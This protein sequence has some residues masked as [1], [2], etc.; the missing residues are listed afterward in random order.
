MQIVK[1]VQTDKFILNFRQQ[2][3]LE[4]RAN[5]LHR[6]NVMFEAFH[7]KKLKLSNLVTEYVNL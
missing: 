4:I 7:L 6:M 2:S 3:N 1:L 5:A